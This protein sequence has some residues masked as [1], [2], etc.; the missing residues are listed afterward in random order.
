MVSA[1][2]GTIEDGIE[3]GTGPAGG[4]GASPPS[5]RRRTSRPQAL[6]ARFQSPAPPGGAAHCTIN[7]PNTLQ[8]A[9]AEDPWLPPT[10]HRW[11]LKAYERG[12]TTSDGA[13]D[14]S[15]S[16]VASGVAMGGAM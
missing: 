11:R 9:G 2:Y 3:P 8:M 5:P 1:P 10:P 7:R 16:G 4:R 15:A 14:D 6:Q 13:E 12:S